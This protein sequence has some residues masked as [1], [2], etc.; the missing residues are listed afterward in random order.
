MTV[1]KDTQSGSCVVSG[2]VLMFGGLLVQGSNNDFSGMHYQP[3]INVG[4]V[5]VVFSPNASSQ[6]LSD[7]VGVD[8]FVGPVK[9]ESR[10]WLSCWWLKIISWVQPLQ[11]FFKLIGY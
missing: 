4:H 1:K 3:Q 8:G 10:L 11:D 7:V 5:T 9:A 6:E 2:S